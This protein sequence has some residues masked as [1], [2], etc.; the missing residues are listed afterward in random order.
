MA[1]IALLVS[2][3]LPS[4]N[5]AKEITRATLCKTNLAGLV[6][7]NILYSGDND[8]HYAPAASDIFTDNLHRWH[9][10]RKARELPFDASLG[11]MAKY[12]GNEGKIKRCP[13]FR[14]FRT[15]TRDGAYETGSG[16]Y[17]YSD[18]YIGS[19]CA[20]YGFRVDSPGLL[21]GVK[22]DGVRNPAETVMFTDAA[23]CVGGQGEI[24]YY[25]EESFCY[26]YFN[27][28]DKGQVI[29]ARP[30]KPSIHF[31]HTF[32]ANVGW[33]DGHVSA[34]DDFFSASVYGSNSPEMH[35]GWFGPKDNSLFDLE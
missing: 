33:C 26:S 27:L 15:E 18:L 14:E 19:E 13:T 8:S 20:Q 31:R 25:I 7:A 1:I 9:G 3:L 17:G 22:T 11:P 28:D 16:G 21:T 24:G 2:M 29:T 10:V 34:R 4:L 30:R 23:M 35:I 6:R 5:R 32:A 12:L